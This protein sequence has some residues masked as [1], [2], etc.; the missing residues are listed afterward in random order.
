V[1][2]LGRGSHG[3]PFWGT[4]LGS[5]AFVGLMLFPVRRAIRALERIYCRREAITPGM[6][7]IVFLVVLASAWITEMLG[8]HALFGAFLAGVVMPRDRDFV[9]ALMIKFADLVT[10]LLLPLFFAFSG[11]RTSIRLVSDPSLWFYFG[12]ILLA[13]IGGKFGGVALAARATGMPGREA[14][15]LGIL[16]NTRGL[17]ELVVLN[18]GLELGV[19]SPTLFTMMVLMALVTTFMTT[20]LLEWFYLAR[21]PVP[22]L[23]ADP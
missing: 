2:A 23:A 13:A 20:P 14:G 1:V 18:L 10:V 8:I 5:L 4:A 12:L 16:M 6:L 9:Q 3:M 21:Q 7:A 19:I 11:L 17:I 22:E 15:A